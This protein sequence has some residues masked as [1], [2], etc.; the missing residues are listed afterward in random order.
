MRILKKFETTIFVKFYPLWM[1]FNCLKA[2]EHYEEAV[3]FLPLKFPDIPGTHLIN[4]R[5]MK[6]LVDLGATKWFW[7]WFP[8]IENPAPWES[9]TY[10]HDWA[11]NIYQ[12]LTDR[13]RWKN[14]QKQ[15]PT[16]FLTKQCWSPRY[17][18]SVLSVC[19]RVH[20]CQLL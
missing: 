3:C 5:R 1:G 10:K 8:W 20:C 11:I 15:K 13:H 17:K 9:S 12:E 16:L 4:L 14:K 18:V 7:S 2:T 19:G 6:F